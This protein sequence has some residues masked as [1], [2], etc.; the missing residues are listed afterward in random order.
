M[1]S[2]LALRQSLLLSATTNLTNSRSLACTPWLGLARAHDRVHTRRL[3]FE[4][5]LITEPHRPT[6][7]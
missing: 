1:A 3:V 7:E 6:Q 5:E 4:N 2:P